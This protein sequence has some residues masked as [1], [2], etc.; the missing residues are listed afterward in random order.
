MAEAA[1]QKAL[2]SLKKL[3]Q[4]GD[5]SDL[6]VTC[7]ED[8]YKVHKAIVCPRS[9]FFASAVQFSGKEAQEGKINL[10]EDEPETIKLLMQYLYE[11]VYGPPIKEPNAT[12]KDYFPHTCEWVN[13]GGFYWCNQPLCPHHDCG[14]G[15]CSYKCAAFIC[16]E[17]VP[18]PEM[19]LLTHSKLYKMGDKYAHH[20]FTSTPEHDK[21]LRDIVSRTISSHRSLMKKPEIEA[22]MLE[23]NGL[24]SGLLKHFLEENEDNETAVKDGQGKRQKRRG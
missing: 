10:P 5:F 17:C 23:L 8:E 19:G 11:G 20:A 15:K 9:T 12:T 21:G 24:A 6:V 16:R 4:S 1:R 14:D 2:E 13:S 22:L 18:L 7:G 3:L